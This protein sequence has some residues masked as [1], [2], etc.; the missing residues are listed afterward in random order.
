M[1]ALDR[2]T[3]VAETPVEKG[4]GVAVRQVCVL[5]GNEKL[6]L[7]NSVARGPW[8]KETVGAYEVHRRTGTN[9]ETFVCPRPELQV[10][11][12]TDVVQPVLEGKPHTGQACADVLSLLSGRGD[13]LAY[14]A[15]D[16]SSPVLR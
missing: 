9:D 8:R 5:E 4:M 2:V 10:S 6:G 3:M 1:A 16:V 12:A 7:P 11:G 13:N 15:M 14:L